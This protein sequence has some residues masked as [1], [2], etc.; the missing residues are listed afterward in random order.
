MLNEMDCDM[1][2]GYYISQALAPVEFAAW[3]KDSPWPAAAISA[4]NLQGLGTR[5]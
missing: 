5:D 3:L 1:A 4:E 2:Q